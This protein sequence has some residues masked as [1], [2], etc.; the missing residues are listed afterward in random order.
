M[1]CFCKT[2]EARRQYRLRANTVLLGYVLG[3]SQHCRIQQLFPVALLPCSVSLQPNRSGQCASIR[4]AF[5]VFVLCLLMAGAVRGFQKRIVAMQPTYLRKGDVTYGL[6]R[7]LFQVKRPR[8]PSSPP[9]PRK[10]I[11]KNLSISER[12]LWEQVKGFGVWRN[13]VFCGVGT[14]ACSLES[15]ARLVFN[16]FWVSDLE[17]G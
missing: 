10:L 3:P 13:L 2:I 4:L 16:A 14:G 9:Q 7:Q 15:T 8:S 5:N 17:S 1:F 11:I 6:Y 12:R